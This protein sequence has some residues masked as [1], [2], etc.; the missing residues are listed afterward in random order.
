MDRKTAGRR[1]QLWRH[2]SLVIFISMLF[3]FAFFFIAWLIIYWLGYTESSP[4][5]L[6]IRQPLSLGVTLLLSVFVGG[7]VA[8]FVGKR[9]IKPI[10]KINNA[11][12][13]LSKG[14]FNIRIST[15]EKIDEMRDIAEHFNDMAFDLSHVETLRRFPAQDQAIQ[16]IL[17]LW[18]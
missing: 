2:F 7:V 1:S 4:Y 9:I 11:F 10:Q 12:D 16:P 3:V 8:V 14:N 15:D 17:F 13:E 5:E 6:L 18:Q